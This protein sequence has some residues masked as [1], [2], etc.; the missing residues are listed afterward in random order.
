VR[1]RKD[2]HGRGGD[3]LHPRASMRPER[4]GSGNAA[5]KAGD[6]AALG[7]SMRPKLQAPG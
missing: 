6:H 5:G 2:G 7:A 1:L 4:W 3:R